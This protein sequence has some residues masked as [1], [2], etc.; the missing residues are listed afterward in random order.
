MFLSFYHFFHIFSHFFL[1][2]IENT[3]FEILR[4]HNFKFSSLYKKMKPFNSQWVEKLN[5]MQQYFNLW[6]FKLVICHVCTRPIEK[7]ERILLLKILY[8][9]LQHYCVPWT[10]TAVQPY[11]CSQSRRLQSLVIHSTPA[12]KYH[13]SCLSRLACRRTGCSR[14]HRRRWL[15]LCKRG[16]RGVIDSWIVKW[17]RYIPK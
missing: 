4:F 2:N 10:L 14:G 5:W 17:R 15:R 12:G 8:S 7:Y 9:S 3:N 13:S 1:N 16:G 11:V 6:Y